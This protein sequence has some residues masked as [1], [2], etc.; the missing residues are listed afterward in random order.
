LLTNIRFMIGKS[1][2]PIPILIRGV[3]VYDSKS[4]LW[5][6]SMLFHS[7]LLL[8]QNRFN[9]TLLPVE[10]G[11]VVENEEEV[12]KIRPHIWSRIIKN[13]IISVTN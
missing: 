13:Y 11:Q 5:F 4:E 12:K 2:L 7:T 9:H 10:S 8:S 6:K 3:V 1:I